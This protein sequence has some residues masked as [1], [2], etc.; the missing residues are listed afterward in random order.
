VV[1]VSYVTGT[2]LND[3]QQRLL[4]DTLSDL[5]QQEEG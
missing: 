5:Y 4:D 3:N 2:N 1:A